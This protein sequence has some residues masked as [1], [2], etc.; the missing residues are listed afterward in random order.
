L[1]TYLSLFCDFILE[2]SELNKENIEHEI[3]HCVINSISEGGGYSWIYHKKNRKENSF[4]IIYLY[5][6]C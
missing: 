2:N 1:F 6:N 4:R 3:G 5:R